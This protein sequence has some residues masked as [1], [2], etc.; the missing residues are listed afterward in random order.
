MIGRRPLSVL[1]WGALASA[2]VTLVLVLF[3]GGLAVSILAL[4]RHRDGPPEP[5][6]IFGLI[7]GVMGAVLMLVIGLIIIGAMIQGAVLRAE[8][9]PDNR[10]FASLRLGRRE[11]WLIAVNFVLGLILGVVQFVLSIP[12]SILSFGMMAG[13]IGAAN[14]HDPGAALGSMAGFV[15]VRAIGQLVI[16]VVTAWLWLRLA[17]GPVMSFR[18]REFRLFES[19]NL[20]KG[21]AVRMF[22]VMLLVWLM[23]LVLYFIVWIIMAATVGVTLF[24]NADLQ[25]IQTLS[26]LSAAAWMARLTPVIAVFA[27]VLVVL[28][29]AGNAMTWGAV[30]R[31]YRQL[32][33]DDDV[34][35]TFA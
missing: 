20:T 29:G 25:N 35:T 30:A 13:S 9:E 5:A 18:E 21:H 10:A 28:V 24:A 17:M 1:T 2:F 19:W 3:G 6:Q 34:A 11:L 16:L 22:L 31:M 32:H 23:M 27:V 15:G 14:T 33:P 7:G 26:S 4:A 12:L 8:L